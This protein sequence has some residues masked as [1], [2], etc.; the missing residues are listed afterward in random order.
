MEKTGI[1]WTEHT[2]NIFRA[3]NKDTQKP[4]WFCTKV[5]SGCKFCYAE[6]LNMKFGNGLSYTIP[7]LKNVEFFLAATN[8]P[9]KHKEPSLFFV[10]SMTDTFLKEIPDSFRHQLFDIM[11]QTPEHEYQVLT[12]RPDIM[13][14]FSLKR[15][16]PHNMW[17]GMSIPD[18][19]ARINDGFEFLK[20]TEAA[21][22]DS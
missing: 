9:F 7:N 8:D 17:A 20:K 10:N 3:R 16:L 21:I 12:K 13:Y 15:K 19:K 5:N 1:I 18:D 4:G 11:E 6:T 2:W 14:E 22:S